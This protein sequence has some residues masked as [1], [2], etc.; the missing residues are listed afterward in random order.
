MAFVS[1]MESQL[2]KRSGSSS[3]FSLP[4]TARS[5]LPTG[6]FSAVQR[7]MTV[8]NNDP[9]TS[10]TTIS[11]ITSA[12]QPSAPTPVTVGTGSL[13]NKPA[14]AASS[15]YQSCRII[16]RRLRDVPDFEPYLLATRS[17]NDANPD[18][19]TTR[20]PHLKDPVNELW[21]CFRLGSSL[22]HLYNALLPSNPLTVRP[23]ATLANLNAC[24]A[25]VYHFLIACRNELHFVDEEL[26]SI[27]ELYSENTTGFVK[28]TRTVSL[29][30]DRLQASDLLLKRDGDAEESHESE[31]PMDNRARVMAELLETERKYVQHLELLQVLCHSMQVATNRVGLY[32][33]ARYR[34]S[35]VG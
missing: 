27:S 18:A 31:V 9:S 25:G 6:L 28:V 12:N 33:G 14:V 13:F 23:D 20:T 26:F 17:L 5:A 29:V 1:S 7:S 21:R 35:G 16:E 19:S 22:C 32:E 3:T 2:G 10:I 24:K 4:G 15:L 34:R 11:S 8:P 30:L